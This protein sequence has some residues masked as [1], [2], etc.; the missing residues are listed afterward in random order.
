MSAITHINK[1]AWVPQ[2]V[3]GIQRGPETQKSWRTA[4]VDYFPPGILILF[5]WQYLLCLFYARFSSW[6]W[7]YRRREAGPRC[8]RVCLLL[9]EE[10]NKQDNCRQCLN[11]VK[12]I[13]QGE[14]AESVGLI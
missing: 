4:E 9:Y 2:Q 10:E 1:N 8:V 7:A 13:K 6:C 11:V 12:K 5:N 14:V 3:L